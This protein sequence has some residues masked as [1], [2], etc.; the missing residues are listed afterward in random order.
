VPSTSKKQADFMRAV[1]HSPKFA[2]QVKVPQSVGEDFMKADKKA[3]RFAEGGVTSAFNQPQAQQ[4]NQQ[5]P[6]G[7]V[8]MSRP[9][10]EQTSQVPAVNIVSTPGQQDSNSSYG[11]APTNFGLGM[12]RGGKVKAKAY[13]AGGAVKSTASRRG[14]GI[15]TKGK[16]RGRIV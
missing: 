12:K 3:K 1:A 16:T 15:A 14:D 10:N 13:K 7:D 6:V 2:K 4:L 8:R 5:P 9:V 11:T